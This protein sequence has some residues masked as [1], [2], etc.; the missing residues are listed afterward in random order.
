[1]F[2]SLGILFTMKIYAWVRIFT[3]IICIWKNQLFL[4]EARCNDY[5][6]RC[7]SELLRMCALIFRNLLCPQ[8]FLAMRLAPNIPTTIIIILLTISFL[9]ITISFRT[10]L[11]LVFAILYQFFVSHQMTAVQ[12]L[13]KV[14]HFI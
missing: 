10:T 12:K 11:K 9:L 14:F 13:W 8:K 7:L 2:K 1:M 3:K 6:P 4:K 5:I